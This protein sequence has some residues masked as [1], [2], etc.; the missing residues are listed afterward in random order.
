[1]AMATGTKARLKRYITRH[2]TP[3]AAL[4]SAAPAPKKRKSEEA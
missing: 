2:S 4:P 1:M 3:E